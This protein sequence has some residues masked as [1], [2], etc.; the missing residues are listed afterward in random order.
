M[1]TG[2]APTTSEWSTIL[3]PTMMWLILEV[4]WYLV[5]YEGILRAQLSLLA[6]WCEK[7][8]V[9]WISIQ[10]AKAIHWYI[11]PYTCLYNIQTSSCKLWWLLFKMIW[12]YQFILYIIFLSVHCSSIEIGH[13]TV[14]V[15]C[16]LPLGA[17]LSVWTSNL[18]W[19]THY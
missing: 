8:E 1:L 10:L 16:C 12:P 5:S 18:W 4:W 14:S 13:S 15:C 7:M 6:N 17:L 19:W 11:E 9:F 2:D 3:L